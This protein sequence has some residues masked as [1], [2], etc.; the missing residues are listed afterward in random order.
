MFQKVKETAGPELLGALGHTFAV[1]GEKSEAH[2]IIKELMRQSTERYV[3]PY[4]IATIYAG[5]V[6]KEQAFRWLENGYEERSFYLRWLKVDPAIDSL[7]S[8]PRFADLLQRVGL[9]V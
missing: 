8:D 2:R 9:T 3:A 5:L 7:R 6:E 4:F 1:S